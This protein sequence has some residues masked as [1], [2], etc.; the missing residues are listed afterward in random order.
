[1]P[2][3]SDD[4]LIEA[5]SESVDRMADDIDSVAMK[6]MIAWNNEHSTTAKRA[7]IQ[8]GV[9]MIA[10]ALAWLTVGGMHVAI[11]ATIVIAGCFVAATI[12]YRTMSVI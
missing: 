3:K 8:D 9:T 11:D 10:L 2:D 7:F 6:R 5:F 12:A 1:M 4:S